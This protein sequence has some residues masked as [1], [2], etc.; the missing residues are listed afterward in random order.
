M[1]GGS[2]GGYEFAL[3]SKNHK[4]HSEDGIHSG[5]KDSDRCCPAVALH[6]ENDL[7]SFRLAYPVALHFL[8]GITPVKRI[9]AAQQAFRIGGY[10]QLPLFHLSLLHREAAA[11]AQTVLNLVIGEDGAEAFAPIDGSLALICDSPSHQ[12][13]GFL[14]F[15]G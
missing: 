11:Y 15:G 7:R 8:E 1:G 10:T 3:G 4:G 5:S 2:E 14:F 12:D 9:E 13:V 6:I